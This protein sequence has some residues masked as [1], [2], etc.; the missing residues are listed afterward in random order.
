M[1]GKSYGRK[2]GNEMDGSIV[3]SRVM[4]SQHVESSPRGIYIP[5][6]GHSPVD[7]S[8]GEQCASWISALFVPCAVSYLYNCTWQLVAGNLVLFTEIRNPVEKYRFFFWGG[9][10]FWEVE[11]EESVTHMERTRTVQDVV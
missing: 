2:S 11:M 5:P 7:M 9:V 1:V 10:Q 6:A 4:Q 8:P 3:D